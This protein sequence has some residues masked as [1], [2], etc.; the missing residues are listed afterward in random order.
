MAETG[1]LRSTDFRTGS[2]DPGF[3]VAFRARERPLADGWFAA[4]SAILRAA[5]LELAPAPASSNPSGSRAMDASTHTVRIAPASTPEGIEDARQLFFEYAQSFGFRL[6]FQDF[7]QEVRSLPGAYALPSGRLLL[8]HD[9]GVAAGCVALRKLAEDF[10]EMKR[11]YVRPA[12]R[13]NKIGKRLVE[14]IIAEARR[15][16]YQRMRLE[17]IASTMQSAIALYRTFEF[18]EIPAYGPRPMPEALYMERRL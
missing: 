2:F 13:R 14:G 4:F 3:H 17:T 7:D 5:N 9:S 8:A 16:G 18:E 15:L 6:C 10:C 12:Y 1:R 11:L